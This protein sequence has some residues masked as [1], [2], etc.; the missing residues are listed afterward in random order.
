VIRLKHISSKLQKIEILHVAPSPGRDQ[1]LLNWGVRSA[2]TK[3]K[4][5]SASVC[6]LFSVGKAASIKGE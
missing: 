1:V 5:G 6:G 3:R 4:P 2:R